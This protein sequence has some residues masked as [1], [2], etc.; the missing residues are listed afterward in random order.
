MPNN[1]ESQAK[2]RT[3]NARDY[4]IAMAAYSQWMNEKIYAAAAELGDDARKRDLGA[5]FR[6]I[7]GTLNHI[8]LGDQAWLQR[9]QGQPVTM[10][11]PDQELHAD[12]DELFAARRAMDSSLSEFAANLS[13]EFFDQPLA[14]FSITYQKNRVIPAWAALV[15]MFNHQTHHR[16]QVTT[17]L[18]QL[19]KD[20]GV[21]DFP[22]MP[23]FD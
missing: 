4:A 2:V 13:N 17:L 18:K 8:L 23:F 3:M 15:H 20:P 9:L 16:G 6:S 7:H 19:G 21:T 12:F 11:S 14:F 22:W 10:R 5:F 1:H